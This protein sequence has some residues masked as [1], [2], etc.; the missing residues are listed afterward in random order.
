MKIVN[1]KGEISSAEPENE[2]EEEL[3][4]SKASFGRRAIDTNPHKITE[5]KPAVRDEN[6]VNIFLGSKFAFSLD[7]TQVVDF[8]LKV[9][10]VLSD[11]EIKE[12]EHASEF[13]KLYNNT[14]EWAMARPRSVKETRDHL[15]QKLIRRKLDNQRRRINAE[16]LKSNPELELKREE[17]KIQTKERRLFSEEDAEKVIAKLVEK[18]YVDDYRFAEWY[19]EARSAKK[20]ISLRRLKDE[21]GRKGVSRAIVDELIEKSDRDDEE[22]AKKIIRKKGGRVKP[23]KLLRYLATHGFDYEMSKELVKKYK[24]DPEGF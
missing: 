21:L 12:L 23:D 20:G 5:M 6:R 2:L 9:G 7:I 16:R 4:F 13:G 3:P 17:Y 8:H 24:E 15:E 18:K 19:I 10:L 22:E 11:G 1:L 14:L